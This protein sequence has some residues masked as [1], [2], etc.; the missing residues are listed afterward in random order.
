MQIYNVLSVD[1]SFLQYP[2][3]GN[4]TVNSRIGL[5]RCVAQLFSVKPAVRWCVYLDT[6]EQITPVRSPIITNGLRQALVT[7]LNNKITQICFGT[8]KL[9]INRIANIGKT[10]LCLR[11][12]NLSFIYNNLQL[13][14]EQNNEAY[15]CVEFG[16]N[17][18]ELSEYHYQ[19]IF[20]HQRL[21]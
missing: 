8:S 9:G 3:S 13:T 2:S 17:R 7:R 14:L 6:Q 19:I 12:M 21:F 20:S 15:E 4:L 16:D 10:C 11:Q 18:M 5:R 1:A